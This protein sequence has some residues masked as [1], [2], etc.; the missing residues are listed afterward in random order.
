VAASVNIPR[1]T[2]APG[3]GTGDNGEYEYGPA[4]VADA[5]TSALLV[6]DRTVTGGFNAAPEST[7]ADLNIYQSN[8][9]GV[10]YRF[11]ASAHIVGGQIV[12]DDPHVPAGTIF[13]QSTINV[14]YFP[15]ANRRVK[16]GLAIT[17]ASV[18]I[19]GSLSTQ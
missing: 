7:A 1:R 9:G 6:I 18:A 10:T 12:N 13:T 19:A 15:G 16:C 17:G 2:L 14:Q 8:D 5:D 4:P 3:G 11:L